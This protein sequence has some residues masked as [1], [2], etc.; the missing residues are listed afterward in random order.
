MKDYRVKRLNKNKVGHRLLDTGNEIRYSECA[1]F[2]RVVG[3]GSI[4]EGLFNAA[5]GYVHFGQQWGLVINEPEASGLTVLVSKACSER[6]DL[7]REGMN[8][9]IFDSTD[10]PALAE[11]IR[12]MA[13]CR[14]LKKM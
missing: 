13:V 12:S 4:D 5:F 9:H 1:T 14:Y 8:G 7:V 10:V 2:C 6:E 11:R 3:A